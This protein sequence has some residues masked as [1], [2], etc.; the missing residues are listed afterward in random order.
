MHHAHGK[1]VVHRAIITNGCRHLLDTGSARPC[2]MCSSV[3]RHDVPLPVQSRSLPQRCC[4]L[5][6]Q[7]RFDKF[8]SADFPGHAVVLLTFLIMMLMPITVVVISSVC[9]LEYKVTVYIF[10]C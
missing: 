1:S 8:S 2:I 5:L 4:T 6:A 9:I 10:C 7:I 3:T